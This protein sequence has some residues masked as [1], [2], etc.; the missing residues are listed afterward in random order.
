[1]IGIQCEVGT[2]R[3]NGRD[4]QVANP[5]ASLNLVG[6]IKLNPCD[7]KGAVEIVK[8]LPGFNFIY[9][10]NSAVDEPTIEIINAS[11]FVM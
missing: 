11:F 9:A 2:A 10:I 8:F 7:R 4:G 1:V 6:R 5:G 3:K